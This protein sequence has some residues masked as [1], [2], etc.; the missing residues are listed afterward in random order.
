MFRRSFVGSFLGS[1]FG[2]AG[3]KTAIAGESTQFSKPLQLQPGH[4]IQGVKPLLPSQQTIRIWKMGSLEHQIYPTK[5]AIDAL[6]KLLCPSDGKP[7][8]DIIWG[9]DLT[10]EVVQGGSVNIIGSASK[11]GTTYYKIKEDG[12]VETILENY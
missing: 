1:L 9:P 10:C 5:Q 7:V 6:A 12:T 8:T 3:A 11:D 4:F 2:F